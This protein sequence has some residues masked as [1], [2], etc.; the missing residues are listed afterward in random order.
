MLKLVP[1]KSAWVEKSKLDL[2]AIYRRPKW[3]MNE[4][5][6]WVQAV[7]ADG[8]TIWDLTTPLRVLDHNKHLAKGFE[9][10]TLASREDLYKAGQQGLIDGNWR[11]YDQHQSGGPWNAKMYLASAKTTDTAVTQQL[12]E[13]IAKFGWETVE[14]LGRR[15]DPKF[16][17]PDVLK[18][19]AESVGEGQPVAVTAKRK[20]VTV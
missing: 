11:E 5:D 18:P 6:E 1:F 9:Y 13:D 17:V 4:F 16:R 14:E 3:V 7:D 10:V 15:R 8:T 2:K 12:R 20:T 19:S